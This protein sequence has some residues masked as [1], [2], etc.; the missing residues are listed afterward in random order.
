MKELENLKHILSILKER[1]LWYKKR[2]LETKR[3][4]K[5]MHRLNIL[6]E[7]IESHT[8]LDAEINYIINLIGIKTLEEIIDEFKNLEPYKIKTHLRNEFKSQLSK[9]KEFFRNILISEKQSTKL[10]EVVFS[11]NDDY[12]RA[13]IKK[14]L[15]E[16]TEQLI[17]RIFKEIVILDEQYTKNVIKDLLEYLQK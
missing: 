14:I 17:T 4:I 13:T 8:M 9:N 12:Q 3:A 10:F 2:Q 16:F 7:P 11:L 6:P 1:T 15:P 5:S